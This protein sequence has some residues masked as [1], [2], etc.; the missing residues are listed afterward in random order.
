[1][2]NFSISDL[3]LF[4]SDIALGNNF[5]AFIAANESPILSS[6]CDCAVKMVA[7]RLFVILGSLFYDTEFGSLVLH[8]VREESTPYRY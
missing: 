2:T 3:E 5:Q 1:M 6:G 7:L 4:R 8:W